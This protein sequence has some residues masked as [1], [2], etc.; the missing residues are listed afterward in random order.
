MCEM[1]ETWSRLLL[2]LRQLNNK[3]DIFRPARLNYKQNQKKTQKC[4]FLQCN[5]H[6]RINVQTHRRTKKKP[7]LVFS[8]QKAIF[9]CHTSGIQRKKGEKK[10]RQ[11]G[12][13]LDER[14]IRQNADETKRAQPTSNN[15]LKSCPDSQN[16]ALTLTTANSSLETLIWEI[17]FDPSD[18][19]VNNNPDAKFSQARSNI[20]RIYLPSNI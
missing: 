14:E 19:K 2:V 12:A 15:G 17:H 10:N 1:S 7:C 3:N 20:S 18:S 9:R 4:G 11:P 5:V 16:K 6:T 8:S 13:P